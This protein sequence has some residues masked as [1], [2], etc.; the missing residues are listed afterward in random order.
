MIFDTITNFTSSNFCIYNSEMG[1]DKAG[2][3]TTT[4]CFIYRIGSVLTERKVSK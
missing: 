4:K 3:G 1:A 2:G